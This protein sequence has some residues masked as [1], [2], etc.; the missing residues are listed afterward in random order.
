MNVTFIQYPACGTC[1]KAKKWLTENKIPFTERHIVENTPTRA[2]LTEFYKKS[3]L[4]LKRFFDTSG[5][6]YREL[7]LKD[8]LPTL[9][10]EEQIQLLASNGKLIKR[11]LLITKGTVLVG[12][13]EEEWENEFK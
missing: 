9:S 11:P 7:N 4:P 3:G 10:E 6:V 1:R 2:E 12:F 8:K 13:K 5:M